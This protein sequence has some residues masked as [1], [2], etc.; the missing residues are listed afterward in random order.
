MNGSTAVILVILLLIVVLGVRSY[1]KRLTHGCCGAGGDAPEPKVKVQDKDVRNYPYHITIQVKG[2]H[3][4]NC[5]RRVENALNQM[6]GV[7]AVVDL[8][9]SCVQVRMKQELPRER[10]LD[11]IRRLGYGAIALGGMERLDK[12][13]K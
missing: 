5:V 10:L 2:M 4:K 1:M 9:Q 8:R 13:V 12:D 3:C 11:A 6:Q 7:W